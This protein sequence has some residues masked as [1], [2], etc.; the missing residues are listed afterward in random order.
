MRGVES[1]F[2]L[3]TSSWPHFS[4]VTLIRS[5]GSATPK[6]PV[7]V[8][9]CMW[10]NGVPARAKPVVQYLST[11][12]HS[13]DT[14]VFCWFFVSNRL[15]Y[16]GRLV[17]CALDWRLLVDQC[18]NPFRQSIDL[19]TDVVFR[20]DRNAPIHFYFASVGSIVEDG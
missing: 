20:W 16:V 1:P 9:W 7:T 10:S 14:V 13:S 3:T 4:S 17:S 19:W 15:S 12:A 2:K 8:L 6:E 18:Q 5:N 11:D